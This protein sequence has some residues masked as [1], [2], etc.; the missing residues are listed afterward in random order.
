MSGQKLYHY[1]VGHILKKPCVCSGDHIFS[2]IT[3]TLGQNICLDNISDEFENE[4][5][6]VKS[7]SLGQIL[8]K[9]GVHSRGH[10]FSLIMMK[11]CQNTC[12][13]KISGDLQNGECQVQN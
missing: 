13:D 8:E 6:R 10:I 11:L 5:C 9:P 12:I 2:L 1:N 7:R 4:S 3:I